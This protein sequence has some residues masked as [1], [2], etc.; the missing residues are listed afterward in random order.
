MP[1]ERL[2][3]AGEAQIPGRE[4][5]RSEFQHICHRYFI[6]SGLV[7]GRSVLD[8][9][10][11]AGIGLPFLGRHA[12][13]VVGTDLFQEN[14]RLAERHSGPI[15]SV[16]VMDAH[17]L[18]FPDD[19]FDVILAME[20]IQYLRFPDFIQE[21][22]RVLKP[23]GTLFVCV[24]NPDR[25][26]FMAGR[27]T[28]GYY[29]A[30]ALQESLTQGGFSAT[31]HGAFQVV[32]AQTTALSALNVMLSSGSKILDLF[33]P[34]LPARRIKNTL[35]RVLKYKPIRLEDVLDEAHMLP[36]KK[37]PLVDLTG[38]FQDAH[39]VFLYAIATNRKPS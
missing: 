9:G 13:R 14:I 4:M 26:G 25:P 24:P 29:S 35:R 11:G 2:E 23:G 8:V 36:V 37:I 27:N 6:A 5:S 33:A 1:S 21:V 32:P 22:R 31:T 17:E 39:H 20:V 30:Q 28:L 18:D 19:S 15:I 16:R 34:F 38:M 3:M 7:K 12:N 10:C